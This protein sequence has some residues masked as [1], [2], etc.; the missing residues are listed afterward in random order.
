MSSH[1]IVREKQEPALII[2][3]NEGFN[4]EYL[5]QLLEW[6]PTVFVYEEEHDYL[7]STGIK[8]DVLFTRNDKNI[9]EIQEL[10]RIIELNPYSI[11]TALELLIE[12]EYP[13]VNIIG[14][15]T[16][17]PQ[18]ANYIDKI[19]LVLFDHQLKIFPVKTHLDKWYASGETITIINFNSENDFSIRGAKA[20]NNITFTT[21]TNGIVT[22]TTSKSPIFVAEQIA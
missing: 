13:S 5:G 12:E 1:H 4:E 21:I 10:T 16:L 15:A 7:L 2:Y 14:P 9:P 6:S 11:E 22:I 3:S 19:D 17:L 18:L 20:L 8:I